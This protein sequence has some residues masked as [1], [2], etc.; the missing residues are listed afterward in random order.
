MAKRLVA[1]LA[2][3]VAVGSLFAGL[4]SWTL[5]LWPG[6]EAYATVDHCYLTYDR[7]ENRHSRCVGNWTRSGRGVSGPI[8]G[9][10]IPESWRLITT[11]PDEGYE[12]EVAVPEAARHLRVVA[13]RHQAWALS[14]RAATWGL[15]PAVFGLFTIE[16]VVAA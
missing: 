3:V 12:W 16:G 4:T 13:D 11:E 2:A 10:A 14:P 1:R 5:G 9:I 8:H 7:Q 15:V 6:D